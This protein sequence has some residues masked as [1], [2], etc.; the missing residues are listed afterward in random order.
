L[1]TL[2]A[3]T[4][5]TSKNKLKRAKRG[6]SDRR[7]VAKERKRGENIKVKKNE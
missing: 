4:L 5:Q 7:L 2:L 3:A 6:N 1:K